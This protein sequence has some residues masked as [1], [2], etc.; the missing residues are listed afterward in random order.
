[1]SDQPE[2]VR[3]AVA[4][5]LVESAVHLGSDGVVLIRH[6]VGDPG[7]L[8]AGDERAE[9]RDEAAASAARRPAVRVP[10]VGDRSAV[11]DDEQPAALLGH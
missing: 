5:G 9:R 1:V 2:P 11:G 4:A 10:P 8:V 6:G 3:R 7:D